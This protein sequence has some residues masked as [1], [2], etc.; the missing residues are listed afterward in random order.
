M[1]RI[2]TLITVL[3][4]LTVSASAE[5][6]EFKPKH[7]VEYEYFLDE[8]DTIVEERGDQGLDS[9]TIR[10]L[11]EIAE[12]LSISFQKTAFVESSKKASWIFPGAGQFKNN[13][14][15]SGALFVSANVAVTAG[16]LIT[17]YFLLPE[18]VR[19]DRLNPFTESRS[20]LEE[21]W[22]DHSFVDFLPSL[23]VVAGGIAL[24]VIIRIL[25]ANHAEDLARKNIENDNV[26][27]E[28]YRFVPLSRGHHKRW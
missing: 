13:D 11:N 18:D 14:A 9:L 5:K 20:R 4:I 26:K 8:L 23:G 16:T 19:F 28:P 22:K 17:A 27:F 25:S 21:T 24:N 1:K 10:D 3:L 7:S 2:V 12:N 6:I 15:L